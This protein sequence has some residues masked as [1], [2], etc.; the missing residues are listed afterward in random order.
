MS[1]SLNAS[2]ASSSFPTLAWIYYV[3]VMLDHKTGELIVE[4]G[5]DQT[6]GFF[7]FLQGE[8]GGVFHH[9]RHREI[10]LFGC[11]LFYFFFLIL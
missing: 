1:K 5:G 6:F 3:V 9:S 11:S 2:V 4:V 8:E 7:F 10:R